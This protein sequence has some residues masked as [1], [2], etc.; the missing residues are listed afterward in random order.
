MPVDMMAD[1]V[2]ALANPGFLLPGRRATPP[3]QRGGQAA[4]KGRPR[5]NQ[6]AAF[7]LERGK[8]QAGGGKIWRHHCVPASDAPVPRVCKQV[9]GGQG[10]HP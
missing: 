6:N 4:L 8:A 3:L 2:E 1:L 5:R 9:G 10:Q 7:Y